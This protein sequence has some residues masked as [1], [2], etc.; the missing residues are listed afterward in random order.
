MTPLCVSLLMNKCSAVN[1]D[2]NGTKIH[3]NTSHPLLQNK[4]VL[5]HNQTTRWSE[6]AVLYLCRES[7]ANIQLNNNS[8]HTHQCN[9]SHFFQYRQLG[10]IYT[11]CNEPSHPIPELENAPDLL[12]KKQP[13]SKL[14]HTLRD[15][16]VG[17]RRRFV[18]CDVFKVK[19]CWILGY[20]DSTILKH[21]KGCFANYE[22][23]VNSKTQCDTAIDTLQCLSTTI[24]RDYIDSLWLP[25][26]IWVSKLW[27]KWFR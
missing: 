6:F 23:L 9:R 3:Q 18:L 7:L 27:Y 4:A 13:A 12:K 25:L 5:K 20:L 17:R 10:V 21:H 14:R 24:F 15:K 2:N 26:H 11:Q 1:Q 16:Q 22:F 8:H 19:F